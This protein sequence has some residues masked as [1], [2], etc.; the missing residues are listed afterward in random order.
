MIAGDVKEF[1]DG[2]GIK[3]AGWVVVSVIVIVGAGF[4][5][6]KY[7]ESKKLKVD[8]LISQ[9]ELKKIMKENPDFQ[10]ETSWLPKII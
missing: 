5:Y 7:I 10:P 3:V 2:S 9:F 8:Y 1:L 4:V 6:T